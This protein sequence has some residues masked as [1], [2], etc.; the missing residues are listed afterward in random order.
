[1]NKW[2]TDPHNMQN[3]RE[4]A[5]VVAKLVGF[6]KSGEHISKEMFEL[7]FTQPS[8]KKTWMGWN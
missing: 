7:N 5:E 2:W 4:S 6:C 3:V 8:D 1:M